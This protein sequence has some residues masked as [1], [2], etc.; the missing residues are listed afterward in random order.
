MPDSG[1]NFW[2]IKNQITFEVSQGDILEH[3]NFDII[4]TTNN[5][6]LTND[7]GLSEK[8]AKLCGEA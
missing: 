6:Q 4:V 2:K 1:Y 8:L 7:G 3:K 5:S